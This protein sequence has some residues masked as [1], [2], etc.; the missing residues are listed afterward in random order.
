MVD[1][2][3]KD[4]SKKILILLSL[5][6]VIFIGVSLSFRFFNKQPVETKQGFYIPEEE[7]DSK[8]R[9]PI[10][11]QYA[12][13]VS[14]TSE[15]ELVQEGENVRIWLS[16]EN[17]VEPMVSADILLQYPSDVLEFSEARSLR[18][19][20]SVRSIRKA[21]DIIVLTLIKNPN[22]ASLAEEY[23]NL[24]EVEFSA[25]RQGSAI[26]YVLEEDGRDRSFYLDVNNQIYILRPTQVLVKVE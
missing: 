18:R 25:K 14:L 17:L 23:Q 11:A 5:A 1:I 12:G 6:L 7:F 13:G 26:V 8:I 16:F 15:K 22:V 2:F 10:D 4:K 3:M 9:L 21:N 19:E 24:I 20:Y